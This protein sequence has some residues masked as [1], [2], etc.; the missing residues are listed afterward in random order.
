MVRVAK[1]LSKEGKVTSGVPQGSVLGPLLFLIYIQDMLIPLQCRVRLFADDSVIYRRIE[2]ESDRELLQRDLEMI[3]KWVTENKLV[4]NVN[5]CKVVSFTRKTTN[6]CPAVYSIMDQ[7]LEVVN[8]YKY[9]GVILDKE[10]RWN[11]HVQKITSEAHKTIG[12]TFRN[13]RGTG[14]KTK[15]LAYRTIIRPKLEYCSTA[16]DP[17]TQEL[18]GELEAV[19]KRAAR[20]VTGQIARWRADEE[21]QVSATALVHELGWEKLQVRRKKDRLCAMYCAHQGEG[22]WKELS[23]KLEPAQYIARHDH[24]WKLQ[25]KGRRTNVGKNSFLNRTSRDW[26]ALPKEAF[27][28]ENRASF[29][30]TLNTLT[31]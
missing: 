31:V 15:E 12:F 19:Q 23:G 21:R 30:H 24:E 25:N 11:K 3:Q 7:D 5:K 17:Y 28:V 16:W 10:L 29:K 20:R 13:L 2:S 9:L 4:L 8:E 18:V 1:H 22:G 14:R 6:T 27:E 26:N